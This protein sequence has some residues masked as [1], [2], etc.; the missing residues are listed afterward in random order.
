MLVAELALNHIFYA[1]E[2]GPFGVK[3]DV[4]Q[5]SERCKTAGGTC[6]VQSN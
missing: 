1:A 4:D 2:V 3:G 5:F 6:F